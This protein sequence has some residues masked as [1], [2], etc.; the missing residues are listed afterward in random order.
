M[1]VSDTTS[2]ALRLRRTES[3]PVDATVKHV[4]QLRDRTYRQ[5]ARATD[6]SVVEID[7]AS[8][9][10]SAGDVVVFTDYLRVERA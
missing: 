4:D 2:G 7:A 6:G 1:A 10:L 9:R 8:T 5:I 3:V